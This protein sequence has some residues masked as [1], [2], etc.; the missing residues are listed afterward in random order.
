MI[1][2]E[3][4]D[5]L[6]F[7]NTSS[8][9]ELNAVSGITP[10]EVQAILAARPFSSLESAA[11]SKGLSTK[12][13][14]GLQKN[15]E[16]TLQPETETSAAE[17]PEAEIIAPKPGSEKKVGRILIRILIAVLILAA[18]FAAVYFGI[19]L[20]KEKILNPLQSNTARVS[21]V[22]T[23][24][25]ADV[26]QLSD[27]IKALNER[28]SKLET[29]ADAVDVALQTHT[30]TLASLQ[31]M[32][33]KLQSSL[34]SQKS[35]LASQLTLTRSIELLS[36]SRLYLSQSNYGL[37]RTDAASARDLLYSLQ[38]TLP[39]AQVD[40]LKIVIERL[41]LALANLPA[42][43]VV[44]VYDIDSAWQLLVDGLPNVPPMAVTPVIS[45][46]LPSSEAASTPESTPAP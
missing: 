5:F 27:E 38:S 11:K 45:A 9:D 37:A 3:M 4:K 42:Y 22:A 33:T 20:F 24:Q 14:K 36:R 18:L 39:A 31:E 21:E 6:E 43:P 30:E 15:Y 25:A 2:V 28:I 46:T 35:D 7:L 19:P 10:A 44:A 17:S 26:K 29:R 23:Q 8:E 41:D 32:Q 12:K 34:E 1:E 40:S 16:E 13:L